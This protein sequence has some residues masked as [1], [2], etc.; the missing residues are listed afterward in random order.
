MN[1]TEL[2]HDQAAGRMADQQA[3]VVAL[4]RAGLVLSP[5]RPPYGLED[6][7]G[8][9]TDTLA[10]LIPTYKSTLDSLIVCRER[11]GPG[12]GGF[13][14]APCPNLSQHRFRPC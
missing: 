8:Q 14:P 3:V 4:D 10:R 1:A 7:F 13:N 6:E 9:D 11:V 12:Q 2:T 5:I